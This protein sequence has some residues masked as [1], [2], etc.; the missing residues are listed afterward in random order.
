MD[1]LLHLLHAGL[2]LFECILSLGG[3]VK[4]ALT[5]RVCRCF[6]CFRT[7]LAARSLD[8]PLAISTRG[9]LEGLELLECSTSGGLLGLGMVVVLR[10]VKVLKNC[11]LWL[12]V[13]LLLVGEHLLRMEN[14]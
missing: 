1:L 12:E 6:H 3:R 11:L 14:I 7:S 13:S 2:A 9:P 8:I 10:R 4:E 5:H